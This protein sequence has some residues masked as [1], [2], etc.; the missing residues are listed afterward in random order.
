MQTQ[1]ITGNHI[2][3]HTNAITNLYYIFQLHTFLICKNMANMK[4]ESPCIITYSAWI[5]C[6]GKGGGGEGGE[7]EEEEAVWFYI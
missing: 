3:L 5:E 2:V 4:T 7:E 6:G 1:R